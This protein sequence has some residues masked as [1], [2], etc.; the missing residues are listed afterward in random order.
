MA[1]TFDLRMMSAYDFIGHLFGLLYLISWSLSF[2]PQAAEN[3]MRKNVKGLS[4]EFA[5]LNP[6]AF[7]LYSVYTMSGRIDNNLGTGIVVIADVLFA[8]HGFA[9]TAVHLT[10]CLIYN[11]GSSNYMPKLWCWIFLGTEI[12]IISFFFILEAN[13]DRIP[14]LL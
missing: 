8:T 4:I 10:Q 2:Y 13:G 3:Y 1:S 9:L 7:F 6:L 12:S 11:R 5:L 14:W